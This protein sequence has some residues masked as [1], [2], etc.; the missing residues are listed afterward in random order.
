MKSYILSAKPFP[1][2]H[3]QGMAMVYFIPL[4]LILIKGKLS[5]PVT[6]AELMF[7]VANYT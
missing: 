6:F 1:T 4:Y 5:V 2:L 3:F 7:Y